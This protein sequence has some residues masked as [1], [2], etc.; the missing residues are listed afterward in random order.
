[1]SYNA[2]CSAKASGGSGFAGRRV[3]IM[4]IWSAN[5]GNRLQNYAMQYTLEQLGFIPF[6]LLR[7]RRDVVKKLKRF[8]R[9][10]V[11]KDRLFACRR[12]DDEHIR[13][14]AETV[15]PEYCTPGYESAFDKFVIGSDQVW[16]PEFPFNSDLEYLPAVAP[17]RKVAYAASF[18]VDRIE[19]N[20]ERTTCLLEGIP[21]VSV[22]EDSGARIVMDLIDKD[23]PVVVDPVMLVDPS[24]WLTIARRPAM[25]PGGPFVASYMVGEG[26][27]VEAVAYLEGYSGLS[28]MDA[29]AEGSE[30]GPEGFLWL[31]ANAEFVCTDSFHACAFSILFHR[32]FVAVARQSDDGDMSSRLDT[33]LGMCG[34]EA[35]YRRRDELLVKDV[36]DCGEDVIDW[37]DVDARL[38]LKSEESLEWFAKALGVG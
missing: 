12:F 31:I 19:R 25:A 27:D 32:P 26:V 7:E 20:R 10:Y 4:T 1:M 35:R 28:M 9:R 14:S 18:G 29:S 17:A 16:N 5:F 2:D 22:R 13:F 24:Q 21:H 15:C 38:S 23:V 34:L 3:A 36:A 30:L 33:L 8:A 37:D 6:T 11:R